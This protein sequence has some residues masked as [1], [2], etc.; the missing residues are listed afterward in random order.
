DDDTNVTATLPLRLVVKHASELRGELEGGLASTPTAPWRGIIPQLFSRLSHPEPYVRESVR[1]LLSRLAGDY[2]PPHRVPGRGRALP[3]PPGGSYAALVDT[4]AAEDGQT[5]TQGVSVAEWASAHQI[6]VCGEKARAGEPSDPELNPQPCPEEHTSSEVRSLVQE[7]RRITLLW[8][9]LWLSALNVHSAEAHRRIRTLEEEVGRVRNNPSLSPAQRESLIRD[10]HAVFLCPTLRV[11]EQLQSLV[12]REAETPHELWFKDTL[13]PLIEETLSALREPADPSRPQAS[14]A[15]LR[16]LHLRLQRRPHDE[17]PQLL[18][19]RVSPALAQLRDSRV[20]MP[21]C[22]GDV[23][24]AAVQSSIAVLPTK[25]KPKK[26][27]FQGSDG[28][29]YT[30]LFKGMEDL[31]L[32]ER[33][34]QLL[35][36][37]NNLLARG[38]GG[39]GN[40]GSVAPRARHYAVTPLG[41]RSGLIQWLDGVTPLF[42]LYKR[43]QQRE[44]A[45]AL[46]PSELFYGK[47]TPLLKEQGITNLDNRREWPVSVLVQTLRELMDETPRDLVARELWCASASAAHWWQTTCSFNR[48]TAVMS[49]VGYVIGLGDR[50]LDN[51]LLDLRSGEVVHIDYN[52]CFEKGKNLRVPE[53]VPFRMTPNIKAALGVTGVEGQFRLACEQACPP[54]MVDRILDVVSMS[55]YAFNKSRMITFEDERSLGMKVDFLKSGY[56]RACVAAYDVEM[57]GASELCRRL[58]PF[59]RLRKIRNLLVESDLQQNRRLLHPPPLLEH[60]QNRDSRQQ[61]TFMTSPGGN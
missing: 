2:P 40:V 42:A 19:E 4:L 25:T 48:S 56:Q 44:A 23:R 46:R 61:D 27:G 45:P 39:G 36:I 54:E 41:S 32:D 28:R 57:D 11:L 47:L 49:I 18:M 24:I 33:I 38:G 8:D 35:S 15:A 50:H 59:A 37:C 30:F 55:S 60:H 34:M 51:V 43:W 17:G 5:I 22:S 26:L 7:L 3:E 58:E 16:R 29:K 31:H 53:K 10:K 21:G 20:P 9:E 12:S 13:G 1:G 52:V 14:W 6:G